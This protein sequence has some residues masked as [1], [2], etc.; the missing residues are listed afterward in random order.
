[1]EE[2]EP[3]EKNWKY[4]RPD[5][6]FSC[7]RS[8]EILPVD[9]WWK[10]KEKNTNPLRIYRWNREQVF[11]AYDVEGKRDKTI[12]G[13]KAA[14]QCAFTDC[15]QVLSLLWTAF[16][17]ATLRERG[18]AFDCFQS[19]CFQPTAFNRAVPVKQ[20]PLG[21]K[22]MV[23]RVLTPNARFPKRKVNKFRF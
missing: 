6:P 7:F 5:L 18:T 21:K 15:F 10:K 20:K 14:K 1:M 12:L 22:R 4:T 17:C 11:G 23:I 9:W 3:I 19:S 13:L 8:G 2:K 16:S